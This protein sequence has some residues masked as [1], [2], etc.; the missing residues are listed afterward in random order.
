LLSWTANQQL[1]PSLRA[2]FDG[3]TST[4]QLGLAVAPAAQACRAGATPAGAAAGAA[5]AA[6]GSFTAADADDASTTRARLYA[7][8]DFVSAHK[9]LPEVQ[10]AH[11]GVAVG[12]WAEKC[13]QLHQQQ[14]LEPDLVTAL[15]SIPDWDWQPQVLTISDNFHTNLQ[16]LVT[17]AQK[18]GLPPLRSQAVSRRRLRPGITDLKTAMQIR[19]QVRTLSRCKHCQ[20]GWQDL[21]Q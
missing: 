10:D 13:R 12:Q 8:Y 2:A 17:Y 5:A 1:V 21:Q 11:Q 16:F 9:R 6:H 18:Y 4:N 7:L 14:G 15:Q 20:F 3:F 19:R